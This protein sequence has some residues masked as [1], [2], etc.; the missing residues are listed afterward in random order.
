VDPEG[1]SKRLQ[2]LALPI[3]AVGALI[4]AITAVATNFRNLVGDPTA[5]GWRQY[6]AI[7]ATILAL[8]L[9][10]RWSGRHRVSKLLDPSALRLDPRLPSHLVGREDDIDRLRNAVDHPLVFLVGESGSG[11]SALLRA[12]LQHDPEILARFL[13]VLLDMA[14]LDWEEGPLRTLV[15]SFWRRLDADARKALDLPGPPDPATLGEAF[16][17]CYPTLGR[18]PLLL[19]DQF[20]D[21]QARHRSR[22]LPP[23]TR[24]WLAP[25][26]LAATNGFWD[27]LRALLADRTIHLLIV[28]RDDTADGLESVRFPPGPSTYR[29]DRLEKGYARQLL[30]RLT[31]RQEP[32]VIAEP[33]RGWIRLRDRLT[34]DL[35][36]QNA[37]LP[38]QL[39]VALGGLRAVLH[40]RLTI[41]A[42]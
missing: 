29:L 7:A 19:L 8:V 11:K 25:L 15:D 18:R 21:Y 6:L 9:L 32:P 26:D 20:D 28:T 27:G 1:L 41:A 24:L 42:Y 23:T 12:G 36:A 14:G 39:K 37:V 30:D 2:E 10:W 40:D 33:E 5:W 4:A 16:A 38:Q 13:P 35:E 3:T 22:F 34:A 17:R 31:G